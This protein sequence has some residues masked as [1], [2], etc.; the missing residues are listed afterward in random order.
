VGP[1]KNCDPANTGKERD[2]RGG[3]GG[4]EEGRSAFL[5]RKD[6]RMLKQANKETKTPSSQRKMFCSCYRLKKDL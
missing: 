3:G 4:E 2:E 6:T 1:R 5:P